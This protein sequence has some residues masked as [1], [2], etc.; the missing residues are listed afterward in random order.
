MFGSL[1]AVS[2]VLGVVGGLAIG[3]LSVGASMMYRINR[4]QDQPL[5][6]DRR[7]YAIGLH[8]KKLTEA[9]KVASMETEV[10]PE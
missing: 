9:K 7:R 4:R 3:G 6:P 5:E 2:P 8:R 1:L 10:K